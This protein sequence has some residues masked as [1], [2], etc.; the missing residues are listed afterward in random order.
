MEV[1]PIAHAAQDADGVW[2]KPHNLVE[3]LV[4]VAERAAEFA[5]PFASSKCAWLAG[6]CCHCGSGK[7]YKKCCLKKG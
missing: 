5:E 3:H 6:L 7:K 2:R 4:G 1:R